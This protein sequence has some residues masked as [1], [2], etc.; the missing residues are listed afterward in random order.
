M[1][2]PLKTT[3]ALFIGLQRS[4]SAYNFPTVCVSTYLTNK[5]DSASDDS[6]MYKRPNANL[7]LTSSELLMHPASVILVTDRA[8]KWNQCSCHWQD[9][10]DLTGEHHL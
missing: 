2:R 7:A 9:A 10:P 5:H 3:K 6:D 1:Y 8:E 4:I